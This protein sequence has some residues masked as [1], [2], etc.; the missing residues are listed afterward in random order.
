MNIHLLELDEHY[1]TPLN[2]ECLYISTLTREGPFY[3]VMVWNVTEDRP[4]KL[5]GDAPAYTTP[6][7]DR[8]YEVYR[9]VSRKV[10]A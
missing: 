1:F 9:Q 7:E 4:L 2:Q 10:A 3:R 8:A 5:W 6:S